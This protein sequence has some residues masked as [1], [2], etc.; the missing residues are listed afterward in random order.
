MGHYLYDVMA[1][2]P[3]LELYL[4]VR[5]PQKLKFNPKS[6]PNVTVIQNDLDNIEK[7]AD[8]IKKMDYVVHLAAA[9]GGTELNYEH[10]LSFFNLLDPRQCK[11]AIYFSTASILGP[12]NQPLEEAEK[13]GSRYILSKYRFYKK[14]PEL[15][16][17]PNVITLF[18]TWVLGGDTRHPYSHAGSGI[19]HLRKWLWLLRFF[20]VDVSFHY[21]HARDIARIV[22]HLLETETKEKDYVLG[23][24]QITADQFI[25]ET[26]RFFKLPVYFRL[27]ISLPLIRTL[28]LLSGKELR[29]W[30]L[31]C[32]EKKYFIHRTVNAEYF[33][34]KSDLRT[35]EQILQ[36]LI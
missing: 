14:L 7:H 19:I 25:K 8:L 33:G 23:N 30:D 6:R 24:P 10:S 15:K 16:I 20:S 34:L 18:P 21:I 12:D 29:S 32:L 5:N 22:K 17:Y 1:D 13:Y 4:L 31:F 11:K 9:W 35:V 27:R 36:D 28:S 3:N 2:D 26:C